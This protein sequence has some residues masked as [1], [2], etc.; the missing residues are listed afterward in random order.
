MAS[1]GEE[2]PSQDLDSEESQKFRIRQAGAVEYSICTP[3]SRRQ[4]PFEEHQSTEGSRKRHLSETEPSSKEQLQR[5][6]RRGIDE[7]DDPSG[8]VGIQ[9][10]VPFYDTYE[11][12]ETPELNV[13]FDETEERRKMPN[14]QTSTNLKRKD[15]QTNNETREW[16]TSPRRR[17][18]SS[19]QG[20]SFKRCKISQPDD[21]TY[22][23][24]QH[25][26]VSGRHIPQSTNWSYSEIE[27][28]DI[29]STTKASYPCTQHYTHNS[30]A[31]TYIQEEENSLFDPN[32]TFNCPL[33]S[34]NVQEDI[35]R[36]SLR[37]QSIAVSPFHYPHIAEESDRLGEDED[38]NCSTLLSLKDGMYIPDILYVSSYLL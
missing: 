23:N 35:Q 30:E 22:P 13:H 37:R 20:N 34:E 16:E 21:N 27:G 1:E 18:I 36:N 31:E 7:Q 14:S 26:N 19:S 15:R 3:E 6:G 25:K 4:R 28:S 32:F 24:P 11:D 33:R 2:L 5:R 12:G 29:F 9:E 10:Y 8:L 38:F 17:S